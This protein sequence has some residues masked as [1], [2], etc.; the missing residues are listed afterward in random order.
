MEW[1]TD[2]T[3]TTI[4]NR[5]RDTDEHPPDVLL[6]IV[7]NPFDDSKHDFRWTSDGNFKTSFRRVTSYI[8]IISDR[9]S[10][11]HIL[12]RKNMYDQLTL[13]ESPDKRT[14]Y[15]AAERRIYV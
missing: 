6:N 1:V 4:K 2:V 13:P 12:K 7:E 10:K 8:L 3:T 5:E 9:Q 15:I 11:I 14:Y